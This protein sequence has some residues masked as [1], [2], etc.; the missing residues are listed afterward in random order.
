MSRKLA[1]EQTRGGES[2]KLTRW[3]GLL[4]APIA[5]SL[6]LLVAYGLVPISCPIGSNLLIHV[7]TVLTL[8]LALVGG[9]FAYRT[10]K[11]AD[12]SDGTRFM[13]IAG[14]LMTGIFIA[15]TVAEWYPAFS[16]GPCVTT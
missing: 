13:G 5:W 12:A 4:L 15:A 1:A 9:V 14:L 8:V 7:A 10:W 16:L 3:V 2:G 6:H 11:L